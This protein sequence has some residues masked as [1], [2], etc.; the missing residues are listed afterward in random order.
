MTAKTTAAAASGAFSGDTDEGVT[1]CGQ[2]NVEADARK[3]MASELAWQAGVKLRLAE[4][5][6][7]RQR[8]ALT[9]MLDQNDTLRRVITDALSQAGAAPMPM[10]VRDALKATA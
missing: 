4:A 10:P 2:E 8:E 1:D 6:L 9:A 3:A 7:D 5:V